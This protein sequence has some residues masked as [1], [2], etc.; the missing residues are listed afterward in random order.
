VT[1]TETQGSNAPSN[2]DLAIQDHQQG[3]LQSAISG[4]EA[5]LREEPQ[6]ALALR[7]GG[8]AAR[9]LGDLGRALDYLGAACKLTNPNP[10]AFCE[11]ALTQMVAGNLVEASAIFH[12]TIG[13]FPSFP[14]ALANLGAL[15]QYRG[16]VAEARQVYEEYLDLEPDDLEIRCNLAKTL[17]DLGQGDQAI[18]EAQ[19]TCER[20]SDHPRALSNLGSVLLDLE[21]FE[22]AEALLTR[23]CK[24]TQSDELPFVNLGSLYLSTQ[25]A[26]E[27]GKVLQKAIELNPNHA[28]AT[29]DYVI[30]LT[31][32]GNSAQ[33]QSIAQEFLRRHPGERSVLASFAYVLGAADASHQAERLLDFDNLIQEVTLGPTLAHDDIAAFVCAHPSLNENPVSKATYGGAQT[34]E[35]DFGESLEIETLCRELLEAVNGRIGDL[36][37]SGV[38]EQTL[39][40]SPPRNWTLR[41]WG[42]VLQRGGRQTPHIHPLGWMSGVYYAQIPEDM[43][44]DSTENGWL[45]F[46]PPPPK[47]ASIE[48]GAKRAIKPETGKLV[49]FPS[50]FYHSTKPLR[51]DEDRV[52]LAFDVVPSFEQLIV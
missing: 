34:G 48:P 26:A 49:L 24:D 35:F 5:T 52:S 4:Y 21:K 18:Q 7:L 13:R 12:E 32:S 3:N 42:T 6:N 41:L 44:V 15:L 37:M 2:L 27:A 10:D 39:M 43:A 9:E 25:R 8:I 33:A 22:Q 23:A 31:A 51:S 46:G 47:Y 11:L 30:A 28:Q 16:H 38:E 20:S 1:K 17:V 50:Y 40:R 19:D 14:K 36:I 45:E 29:A